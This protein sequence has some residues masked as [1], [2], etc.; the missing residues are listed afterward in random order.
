MSEQNDIEE[1]AQGDSLALVYD[2]EPAQDMTGWTCNIAIKK[3]PGAAALLTKE[4]ATLTGDNL[5]FVG[6]LEPA[7][8]ATLP[9]GRLYVFA[10]MSNSSTNQSAQ[11]ADQ[12]QVTQIEVTDP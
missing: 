12:I 1:I 5:A 7:E 10:R 4:I 11:K 2:T 6:A 8:T 9:T 3:T